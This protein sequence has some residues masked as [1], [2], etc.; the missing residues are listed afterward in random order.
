MPKK[1]FEPPFG[2]TSLPAPVR[3]APLRQA[4]PPGA[5]AKPGFDR[6]LVKQDKGHGGRSRPT[7]QAP[8]RRPPSVR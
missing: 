7:H 1:P 5:A 8:R 6:N 4:L 3:P 2:V